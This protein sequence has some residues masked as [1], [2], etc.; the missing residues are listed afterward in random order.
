MSF[1][2]KDVA[3]LR[4]MT[5][6]GMMDCKKALTEVGGNLDEA[7]AFLRQNG[8][9]SA[10]K[11]AGNIAAEGLIRAAVSSDRKTAAV[12]EVNSQ[13]DFAAKNEDFVRF[14]EA[15]A[16]TAVDNKIKNIADL[17]DANLNGKSV[18]EG[19]IELTAKIGEKVDVRRV[20]LVCATGTVGHYVHPVGSKVGVVVAL[21]EDNKEKA[22]DMAMHI[23]AANPAPEYISKNEID[24]ETIEKEK[25]IESKKD[26]LAGKPA[27]MVEKI[28]GGRVDKILAAKVLNEQ[29]F[30]KDPGQKIS[31]YLG[32]A[33]VES[34]TRLDLGAGVEK[35]TEDYAAEVA[36][37]MRV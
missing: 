23:A 35:K 8:M 12:V 2:A 21:S 5:G 7:V 4:Q 17:L 25:E 19:A 26:D 29:A 1:T 28:V 6:A 15:V 31:Q 32:S 33:K 36:A 3:E 16:K 24:P 9:A 20:A 13:T 22:G 10:A 34:F 14:T 27:E 11:K 30:I 18:R 37:A